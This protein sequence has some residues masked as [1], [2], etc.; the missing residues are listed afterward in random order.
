MKAAFWRACCCAASVAALILC[1]TTRSDQEGDKKADEADYVLDEVAKAHKNYKNIEA[2]VVYTKIVEALD[3]RKVSKGRIQYV[4]PHALRLT[5]LPPRNREVF[6]DEKNIWVVEHSQKQVEKYAK[7]DSAAENS[8]AAFL[9]FAYKGSTE[10]VRKRYKTTVEKKEQ[11]GET[12]RYKLDLVPK[13]KKGNRFSKIEIW[14]NSK[15]WLPDAMILHES[16]GEFVQSFEFSDIQWNTR[17]KEKDLRFRVPRGYD[18]VS[19]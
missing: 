17:L 19:P 1:T 7:A 16:E 18:V 10:E 13:E 6:M 12:T 8:E 11:Q 9:E 3:T 4:K 15:H 14:F 5:L 2:K